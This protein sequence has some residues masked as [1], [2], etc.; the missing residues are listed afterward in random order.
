MKRKLPFSVFMCLA[1]FFSVAFG[2]APIGA[3]VAETK[4]KTAFSALHLDEEAMA[5]CPD[6][7]VPAAETDEAVLYVDTSNGLFA[8]Y[9]KRSGMLWYSCPPQADQDSIAGSAEKNAMK[10]LISVTYYDDA[11][12]KA[13]YNAYEHCIKNGLLNC[14]AAEKGITFEFTLTNRVKSL[15]DVPEYISEQRFKKYF[16]NPADEK[17][18]KILKKRF[19]QLEDGRYQRYNIPLFEL[20]LIFALMNRSG[21]DNN[22]LEKDNAE[23]KDLL[24]DSKTETVQAVQF[25][26]PVTVTLEEADVV[27]SVDAGAITKTDGY[28]IYSITLNQYYGAGGMQ[29]EGYIL[30]P[31]GCG[32]LINLNNGKSGKGEA[33][34][35]VLGE[36]AATAKDSEGATVQTAHL[37]VFGIKRGDNGVF[38]VMEQ[39]AASAVVSALTSGS[40]SSYNTAWFSFVVE[41][42]GTVQLDNNSSLTVFEEKPY[43]GEFS[44]R[45]QFCE[46]G[47]STYSDMAALY[48][49]RLFEK[50]KRLSGDLP[51]YLQLLGSVDKLKTFICF[52][53]F[54][55]EVLTD[56]S[57]AVSIVSELSENGVKNL[58]VQYS[59]ILKGGLRHYS[60]LKPSANTT[61]GN[62]AE[63]GELKEAL[64]SVGG[65]IYADAAF[66]RVYQ[67][68]KGFR[69]ASDGSKYLSQKPAQLFFYSPVTHHR[70]TENVYLKGIPYDLILSASKFE[71]AAGRFS[72]F[73]DKKGLEGIYLPDLGT[74]VYGDYN[75]KK[76]ISREAALQL[77]VKALNTL[78]E[79][80]DL[81]SK[82]GNYA[83]LRYVNGIVNV[84][85]TDTGYEIEDEAVPFYQMV[86]HG[87]V[88]YA[89]APV[90]LGTNLRRS[91]LKALE[92]GSSLSFT[93][94]GASSDKLKDT[95]YTDY[96][97]VE[98]DAFKEQMIS[99]YTELNEVLADCHGSAMVSHRNISTDLYCT[100][101]ENGKCIYVNYS[102]VKQ[103]V[104]TSSGD[105]TVQGLSYA[106]GNT[107]K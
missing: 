38:A 107:N 67:N 86:L 9:D 68:G 15:E 49:N 106:I 51:S 75:N 22:E 4:Q 79:K 85:D 102:D 105:I 96:Y 88:D 94:M 31:D 45:Y 21:Y 34:V 80:Y 70:L 11:N 46:T 40:K 1:V 32:A 56:Y 35:S 62:A 71:K 5:T 36:D 84:P 58:K 48:R 39:G 2:S 65:T 90:N 16:L 97:S 44:V 92:Y 47:K 55:N 42:M 52:Q 60:V 27:L 3:D 74:E 63:F 10:S 50:R 76:S 41:Q 104:H 29:E 26:I 24:K 17:E 25:V 12:N 6:G 18:K 37:P 64:S 82:G 69:Y 59:G 83:V 100:E 33:S 57:Q 7:Y 20:K 53:Y 73:M 99:Y 98:Y 30:L 101:Y 87:Y 54:G 13:A 77:A 89:P 72:S 91:F 81:I 78:S 66:V 8:N 103:T 28:Y 23:N 93:A 61:L 14:Y 43:D 95:A 19:K